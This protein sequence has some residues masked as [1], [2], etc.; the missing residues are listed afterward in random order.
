MND[1]SPPSIAPRPFGGDLPGGPR[2]AA[3]TPP[4]N[5]GQGGK[6]PGASAGARVRE[7]FCP[8]GG[9]CGDAETGAGSPYPFEGP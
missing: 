6:L 2:G 9:R 7:W 8:F 3:R 4:S 1:S 5:P